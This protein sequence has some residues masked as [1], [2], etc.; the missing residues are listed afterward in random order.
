M[1]EEENKETP[2]NHAGYFI[3]DKMG[4]MK[5]ESNG[6][7]AVEMV[8]QGYRAFLLER[9]LIWKPEEPKEEEPKEE[10]ECSEES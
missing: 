4:C 5:Y 10:K 2:K 7:K 1:T 3:V 6:E 8:K 9:E